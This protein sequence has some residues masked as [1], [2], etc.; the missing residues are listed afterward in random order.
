MTL[1][2]FTLH[3]DGSVSLDEEPQRRA[4]AELAAD[5]AAS[6]Q[7]RS[8]HGAAALTTLRAVLGLAPW[9]G[10]RGHSFSPWCQVMQ[11]LAWSVL[12]VLAPERATPAVLTTNATREEVTIDRGMTAPVDRSAS[13]FTDGTTRLAVELDESWWNEH[14]L[15]SSFL[16]AVVRVDARQVSLFF[17][18]DGSLRWRGAGLAEDDLAKVSTL[19]GPAQPNKST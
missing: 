12:F 9:P 15:A 17:D 10:M 6:D 2:R 18:E 13:T 4:R 7:V 5:G 1:P 19:L 3:A 14:T 11:D 16:R 8:R